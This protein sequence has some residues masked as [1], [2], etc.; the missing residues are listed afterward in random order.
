MAAL[1]VTFSATPA[2]AQDLVIYDEVLCAGWQGRSWAQVND[3]L[4]LVAVPVPPAVHVSV[5]AARAVRAVHERVFGVNA[6]MWDEHLATP[7]A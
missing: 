2:S 6:T 7:A 5:E 4:T 1:A 3:D